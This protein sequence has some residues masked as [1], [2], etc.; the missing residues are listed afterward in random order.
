LACIGE[1]TAGPTPFPF[2]PASSINRAAAMSFDGFL[3]MQPALE[4]PSVMTLLP[5]EVFVTRPALWLRTLSRYRADISV[6]PNFAYALCL[7][8][9][10][11]EE[12][13]GVDLSAWQLALC[14]AESV[15]P[16]V[17]VAFRD[18]FARWGFPAEALTPV[19]GLSEAAL[20]VT[21]G[22]LDKPFAAERWGR[23]SLARGQAE[24]AAPEEDAVTLASVGRPLP[25]FG[26]RILGQEDALL[27]PGK[28]GRLSVRGPSLME[29]YFGCAQATAAVLCDGWL[30]TGDLGFLDQNGELYLTGRAKDV[31]ILRGRNHDP[32]EVEHVASSVE[33]ARHGCAV[34]VSRRQDEAATEALLVFVEH[35]RQASR[36]QITA[37][38]IRVAAAVLVATGLATERVVVLAP[39][40]LPRTSSGKLRR[41]A[42]L[43]R[44]EAGELSP[45][46]AVNML[47]LG[48]AMVRSARAFR[49]AA[50]VR[51]AHEGEAS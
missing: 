16:S 28:V 31:L 35:A 19:Y 3:K 5:P 17:L 49:R 8:K 10:R 1:T 34:A 27:P 36:E 15:S 38:S 50:R 12:L 20:A 9:I 4:L 32:A 40:S 22:D 29:G 26:V 6:A 48:A 37:L 24:L 47:T 11:D 30:D 46:G 44:Y 25:G 39:G 41:G 42:A 45:P 51:G 21:F 2:Q 33:G 43:A 14:G 18:R 13:E 23:A 7:E